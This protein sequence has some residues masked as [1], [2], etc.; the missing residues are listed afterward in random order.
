MK[1]ML[2]LIALGLLM[3]ALDVLDI[4]R[5]AVS[6]S[7]GQREAIGL[8]V[9][10]KQSKRLKMPGYDA[11]NDLLAAV[12]PNAIVAADPLH[13]K[14]AIVRLILEKGGDFII[15]TKANTAKRLKGAA[16]TLK[17]APFLSSVA[18]T[19]ASIPAKP[20]SSPSRL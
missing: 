1:A 4:W 19:G 8:R 20:P 2:S 16:Q 14:E 18:S 11:L 3:G 5:K 10:E 9:R 7:Q 13:N 17:E 12:D 15:G 6:L